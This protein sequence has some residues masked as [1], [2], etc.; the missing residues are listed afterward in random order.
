[1]EDKAFEEMR[2]QLKPGQEG[3]K[4]YKQTKMCS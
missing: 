3:L 1:M 4:K 2:V